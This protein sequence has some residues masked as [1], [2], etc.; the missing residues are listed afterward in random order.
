MNSQTYRGVVRDGTVVVL[1][2]PVPLAEGTSVLII[3]VP[4]KPGMGA[5]LV[6][7]LAS[8]PPV[9]KEWVDELER[10]IREG[11]R[12]PSPLDPSLRVWEKECEEVAALSGGEFDSVA[13]LRRIRDGD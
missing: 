10:V 3:P 4:A 13:E 11:E 9:P 6:E 2:S 1:G 8:V 12:P 5:A 7:S